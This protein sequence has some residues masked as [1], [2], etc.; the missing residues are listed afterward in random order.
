MTTAYVYKWTQIST[1]KWYVGAR[2]AR[3]CHPDDGYICSSKVVKPLILNHPDD[4]IREILHTGSPDNIFE[5]EASILKSLNAKDDPNSFNKHNG[6]GKWSMRGK[7]FSDEHKLKMSKWQIGRVFDSSSIEK[8]TN[9]RKDFKQSDDA[10]IRISQSLKG[11]RT[12][13]SPSLEHRKKIS[14]TLTGRKNGPLSDEH[15]ALISK[16]KMGYRHTSESIGK[17]KAAHSGKVLTEEHKLKIS[18]SGKGLKKSEETKARM[19]KPKEKRICP[20]CELACAPHML[21]RH[22]NA[23]H[24]N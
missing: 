8:R 7:Q 4:W 13:I 6:D 21:Q 15:K 24:S 18:Q 1:G 11:Q 20:Y 10:K 5:M 2:G 3:G 12:G 23:R 16:V 17:M 14:A 22:I 19:R 9:S